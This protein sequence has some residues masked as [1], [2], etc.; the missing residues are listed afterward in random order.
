V[1]AKLT[2][3]VLEFRWV[4][5]AWAVVALSSVEQVLVVAV[6]EQEAVEEGARRLVRER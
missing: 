5:A 6:V 4:L 2:G 1:V 3:G